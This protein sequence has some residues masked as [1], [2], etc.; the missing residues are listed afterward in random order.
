MPPVLKALQAKNVN[1]V[2][3]CMLS[4]MV[5]R[6]HSQPPPKGSLSTGRGEKNMESSAAVQD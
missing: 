6:K 4:T 3:Y 2:A 1:S 5:S